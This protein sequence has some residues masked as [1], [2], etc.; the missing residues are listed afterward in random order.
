M[1]LYVTVTTSAVIIDTRR[2]EAIAYKKAYAIGE[3]EIRVGLD[4]NIS[5]SKA[6][7]LARDRA[8]VAIAQWAKDRGIRQTDVRRVDSE[9]KHRQ[10][11]LNKNLKLL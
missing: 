6:R 3:I 8:Y 9:S 11:K 10:V 7:G 1:I 4:A 2:V 5:G